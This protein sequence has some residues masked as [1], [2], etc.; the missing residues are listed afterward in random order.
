[1][2]DLLSPD[3]TARLA[4]SAWAVASDGAEATAKVVQMI[5]RMLGED[6]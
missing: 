2:G 6:Q 3:R 5:R 4:Q 1:L